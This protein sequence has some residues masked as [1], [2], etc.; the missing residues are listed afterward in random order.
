MK[1]L[2]NC[3]YGPFQ[4]SPDRGGFSTHSPCYAMR[5]LLLFS[6]L[7]IEKLL[8]CFSLQQVRAVQGKSP[9]GGLRG[10]L[11]CAFISLRLFVKSFVLL[12]VF[13]SSWFN[14]SAQRQD[15]SLNENWL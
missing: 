10:R 6:F 7:K 9:F 3:K 2:S 15:I 5:L 8:N 1:S 11:L 14:S 12:C 13:V 4:T